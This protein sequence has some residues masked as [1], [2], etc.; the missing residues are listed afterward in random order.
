MVPPA[1]QDKT[2][3][4][5]VLVNQV[6]LDDPAKHFPLR[7]LYCHAVDAHLGLEALLDLTVLVVHLELLVSLEKLSCDNEKSL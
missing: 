7:I 4:K 2:A 1:K 6:P 3:T 5:D